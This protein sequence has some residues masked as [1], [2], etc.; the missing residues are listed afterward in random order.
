M[1]FGS[2]DPEIESLDDYLGD[3]K[4]YLGAFFDRFPDRHRIRRFA[5]QR[6]VIN[7]NW[8]LPMENQLGDVNHGPVPSRRRDSARGEPGRSSHV[9]L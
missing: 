7:A 5:P 4:F 2:F 8:K 6:W 9:G 1:I 3:M